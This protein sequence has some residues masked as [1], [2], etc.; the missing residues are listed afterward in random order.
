MSKN[1]NR[2]L[3]EDAK[4][5]ANKVIDFVKDND[6]TNGCKLHLCG[7][8]RRKA[9]DCGDV[10]F[11]VEENDWAIL[12]PVFRDS[13][14]FDSKNI[15]VKDGSFKAGMLDGLNIE[16]YVGPKRGMGALMQ[17]TT[18]SAAHNVEIRRKAIRL[19]YKV[20][21]YGVWDRATNEFIGGETESE[22]YDILGM[23]Y[24]K[25]EDRSKSWK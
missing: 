20:N 7:S 25:P 8:I 5:I 1:P 10:D 23:E 2:V 6:I 18:G 22:F 15:L 11:C 19:G 17:F 12:E 9:K 4:I 16:F 14:I 21:Q 24:L 13:D 3:L